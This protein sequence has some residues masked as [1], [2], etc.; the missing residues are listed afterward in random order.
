MK[1]SDKELTL[2]LPLKLAEESLHPERVIKKI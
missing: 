1:A 2:L